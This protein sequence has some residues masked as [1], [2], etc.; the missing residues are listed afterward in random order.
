VKGKHEE[1]KVSCCVQSLQWRHLCRRIMNNVVG[2]NLW[3]TSIG[4]DVVG[5]LTLI[6]NLDLTLTL[7]PSPNPNTN[8]AI[9]AI[10]T[11]AHR[12]AK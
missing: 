12:R 9:S 7:K 5:H 3:I 11:Q 4:L 1:D 10:L 6:L 2:D 8:P